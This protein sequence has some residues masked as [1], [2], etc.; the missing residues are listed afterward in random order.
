MKNRSSPT[1]RPIVCT[2]G[3]CVS[4]VQPSSNPSPVKSQPNLQACTISFGHGNMWSVTIGNIIGSNVSIVKPRGHVSCLAFHTWIGVAMGGEHF[5]WMKRN[6]G[7]CLWKDMMSTPPWKHWVFYII[8][9]SMSSQFYLFLLVSWCF[10][11]V[12]CSSS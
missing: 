10:K 12:L 5:D 2:L 7:R 3:R 1:K 6:V 11:I 4:V 8:Y 9:I